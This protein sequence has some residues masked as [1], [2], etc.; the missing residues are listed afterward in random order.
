M[1]LV[2]VMISHVICVLELA[3]LD[4]S[5]VVNGGSTLPAIQEQDDSEHNDVLHLCSEVI[6]S[7]ATKIKGC[8]S[9]L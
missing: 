5:V 6:R 7:A 8:R 2:V 9:F 1:H 4:R 3:D